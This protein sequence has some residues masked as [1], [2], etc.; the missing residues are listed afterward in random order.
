MVECH[1][2]KVK[3]AGPNPV[4][5]STKK[6]TAAEKLPLLFLRNGR[7][8]AL[9]SFTK[10]GAQVR[11]VGREPDELNVKHIQA[12][13]RKTNETAHTSTDVGE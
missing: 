12:E 10:S 4:S 1:L 7:D 2:A 3:V 11:A 9:V 5:R 8:S 6:V 13:K